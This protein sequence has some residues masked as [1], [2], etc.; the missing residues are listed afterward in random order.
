MFEGMRLPKLHMPEGL[1]SAGFGASKLEKEFESLS[2]DQREVVK[3]I[4]AHQSPASTPERSI[5]DAVEDYESLYARSRAEV[6]TRLVE[7]GGA[8]AVFAAL[9]FGAGYTAAGVAGT[10]YAGLW[11]VR[12]V[13]KRM[14]LEREE[15][16]GML[17]FKNER[18]AAHD[19]H[20]K[21]HG[22]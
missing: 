14:H 4:E 11:A 3:F 15:E 13:L 22:A 19:R 6:Y 20:S 7:H 21:P 8:G 17:R 5:D 16:R 10:A 2:E 1:S 12:A 9:G 18:D